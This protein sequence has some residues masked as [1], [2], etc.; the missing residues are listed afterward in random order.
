MMSVFMSTASKDSITYAGVVSIC[1][2]CTPTSPVALQNLV[3]RS[4]Y[5]DSLT[6][7]ENQHFDEMNEEER[8]TESNSQTAAGVLGFI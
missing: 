6:P 2:H 5:E 1:I 4:V 7:A 3:I 8:L